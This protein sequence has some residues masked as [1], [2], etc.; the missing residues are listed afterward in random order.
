MAPSA[1]RV[2]VHFFPTPTHDTLPRESW[3][4]PRVPKDLLESTGTT[5]ASPEQR[6][7]PTSGSSSRSPLI[8]L[9]FFNENLLTLSPAYLQREGHRSLSY[10]YL[11]KG[12]EIDPGN[13]KA[14]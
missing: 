5:S 13:I 11:F 1:P 9:A 4:P 6:Q 2:R 7:G 10:R 12:L 3:K 14:S 8:L